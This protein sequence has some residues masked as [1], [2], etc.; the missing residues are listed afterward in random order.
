[1]AEN[2]TVG[3]AGMMLAPFFGSSDYVLVQESEKSAL[4]MN[5]VVPIGTQSVYPTAGH[6]IM[7]GL[8]VY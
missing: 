2:A 1:M 6:V 4:A 5:G 8:S 3:V 7:L